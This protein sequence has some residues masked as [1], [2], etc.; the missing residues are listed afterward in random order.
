MQTEMPVSAETTQYAAYVA[1]M[2]L[3]PA[4]GF[5]VLGAF[6]LIRTGVEK[7]LAAVARFQS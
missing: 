3:T 2:F 5:A 4:V 7:T 6:W 1:A